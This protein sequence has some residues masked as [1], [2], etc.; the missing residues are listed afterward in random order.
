MVEMDR[1]V[2]RVVWKKT[3]HVILFWE[4]VFMTGKEERSFLSGNLE[5]VGFRL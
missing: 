2:D 1:E 5:S 3:K 4:P